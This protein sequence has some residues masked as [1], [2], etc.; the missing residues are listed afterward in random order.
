M[1]SLSRRG[2][3]ASAPGL[4]LAPRALARVNGVALVV[5]NS[6]YQW[7]AP[8]AN[9]RRDARATGMILEAMGLRTEVLL[10]AD[11][12]TLTAALQRL[13]QR[14]PGA[15][16]ALL[17]FAGHGVQRN[18]VNWLVPTDADLQA[19]ANAPRQMVSLND[20]IQAMA[21]AQSR[22][23][24]LDACRND[25]MAGNNPDARG[26][27][28][29][30]EAPAGSLI[31][32]A[33]SPGRVALDGTGQHSPFTDA[34][35]DHLGTP[36]LEFRQVLTRV[37]R[38]VLVATDGQQIPWDISSLINDVSLRGPG[39]AAVPRPNIDP[40]P[41]PA[42]PARPARGNRPLPPQPD[43]PGQGEVRFDPNRFRD[44]PRALAQARAS[45]F[46]FPDG[47]LV[48]RRNA[49]GEP[50]P[51]AGAYLDQRNGLWMKI[52]VSYDTRAMR[53]NYIFMRS[54]NAGARSAFWEQRDARFENGV[55]RDVDSRGNLL[56]ELN[57]DTGWAINATRTSRSGTPVAPESIRYA[58]VE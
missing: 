8:L 6:S 16:L 15:E 7:E 55:L 29:V 27:A 42:A 22:V 2:L 39:E 24:L 48:E 13:A 36:G 26:L 20:A 46:T 33:T 40:P 43:S 28:R 58:R 12:A 4:L 14:A 51:L 3:V 10:D 45:G 31:C 23:I 54:A 38:R 49:S 53:A 52:V 37:R 32:F 5:G 1:M 30:E 57:L 19:G 17:F 9:P 18:N 41:A 44:I 21:R 47:L 56:R 11:R 34:L 25:P 50:T 35:L